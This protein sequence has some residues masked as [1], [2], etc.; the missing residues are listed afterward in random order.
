MKRSE[1][2]TS[3]TLFAIIVMIVHISWPS[4]AIDGIT[5]TLL[6][7]AIVPWLAPILR[8][9]KLPGGMEL[10]F[11]EFEKVKDAAE[12]AGLL[13]PEQEIPAQ[14]TTTEPEYTYQIVAESDPNLALAG[15]RIEIEKRLRAIAISHGLYQPKQSIGKLMRTLQQN[16]AINYQE[17]NALSDI[18]YLLNDAAHGAEIDPKAFEIAMEIGPKILKSLDNMSVRPIN[19]IRN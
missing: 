1:I 3:I 11:R 17:S 5:L 14:G 8:S 7:I 2:Q 19:V 16:E 10:E 13:A 4:L 15:L 9:I 6:A 12:A 18:I